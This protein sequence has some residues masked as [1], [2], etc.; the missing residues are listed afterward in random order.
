MCLLFVLFRASSSRASSRLPSLTATSSSSPDL[1]TE[2]SKSG[3]SL[4]V[5]LRNL[6]EA[7]HFRQEVLLKLQQACFFGLGLLEGGGG[8]LGGIV[9]D[10]SLK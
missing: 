10:G 6:H 1:R 2:P 3:T 4:Q 8:K 9:L 5:R 7:S